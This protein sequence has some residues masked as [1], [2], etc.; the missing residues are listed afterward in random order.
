MLEAEHTGTSALIPR[1]LPLGILAVTMEEAVWT[2]GS[3]QKKH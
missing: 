1:V 2:Y 3:E